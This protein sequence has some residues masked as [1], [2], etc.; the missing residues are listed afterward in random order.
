MAHAAIAFAKAL[1]P[2]AHDGLHDLDRPGRAQHGHR[3]RGGAC[4]PPAGAARCPATSSP[5]AGPTRCCSRSRISATARSAPTTASARSRA[6]STASP[7][8]SSS[9]RPSARAMAVLTDPAE[10]GPVTLRLLPGR[11]DRGLRLPAH[12]LRGPR[13][14][15][16][17]RLAPDPRELPRPP[18]PAAGGADA[19]RHRRRRRALCRGRARADRLLRQARRSRRRDAGRQIGARRPSIPWRWARSASPEPARPTRSRRRPTSC[20]ASAPGCGFHHRLLGA[21]QEPGRRL[22]IGLNVAAVRRGQASRA[23]A[24]RRRP[25][26]ARGARRG[27]R[28]LDGARRPG[29]RR[30]AEAKAEWC[31]VAGALHRAARNAGCPPTEPR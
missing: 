18:R 1:A 6:I 2:P 17:R 19:A 9:S 30:A 10:C 4:Q 29:A 31:S 20:S 25:R 11:A 5:A 16:P 15:A 21:V 27:A 24:G 14:S 26:G 7:G 13:A 8:P 28:R 23:A 3:R 12:L 22:I